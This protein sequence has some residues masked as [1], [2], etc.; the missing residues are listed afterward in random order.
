MGKIFKKDFKCPGGVTCR[1]E[2]SY[3]N[4]RARRARRKRRRLSAFH[5]AKLVW[6]RVRS[7][8]SDGQKG[9][10]VGVKMCKL[11]NHT[12]DDMCRKTSDPDVLRRNLAMRLINFIKVRLG[13]DLNV[14]IYSANVNST[15]RNLCS[16][17][18]RLI[19]DQPTIL[20]LGIGL[21][22]RKYLRALPDLGSDF[23]DFGPLNSSFDGLDNDLSD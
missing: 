6:Q 19:K 8:P 11:H 22:P 12:Y 1:C 9:L 14:R 23:G 20:P 21:W 13:F 4:F 16:V 2:K 15:L 7:S 10:H 5:L 18:Q 3:R 17:M